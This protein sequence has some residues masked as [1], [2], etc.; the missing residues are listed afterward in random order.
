MEPKVILNMIW[1]GSAPPHQVQENAKKWANQENLQVNLITDETRPTSWI[2]EIELTGRPWAQIADVIRIEPF[3]HVSG[4]YMDVDCEPGT[5]PL[6]TPSKTTFFRTEPNS[7]ANGI[8][9]INQNSAFLNTW[10]NQIYA[11]LSLVGGTVASQ[12]GPGALTRAVYMFSFEQGLK[13][14]RDELA[15]AS[16]KEFIHWPIQFKHVTRHLPNFLRNGSIATHFAD[17]S[18]DVEE[19]DRSTFLKTF[20]SA[21]LWRLRNSMFSNIFEYLRFLWLSKLPMKDRFSSVCLSAAS[22]MPNGKLS[23]VQDLNEL[24]IRVNSETELL[25][26]V[27]DLEKPFVTGIQGQSVSKMQAAGW[28][29]KQLRGLGEVWVR[30]KLQDILG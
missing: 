8:F 30:P 27:E 16:F 11:G 17:A 4:W 29:S 9:Y 15:L 7:L 5:V 21:L 10:K 12:T 6:S 24:V 23:T 14:S 19:P 25:A 22:R 26:A 13:K 20:I 3:A 1:I 2:S 28:S 18:W